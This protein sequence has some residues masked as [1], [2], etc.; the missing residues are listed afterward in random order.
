MSFGVSGAGGAVSSAAAGGGFGGI[1]GTSG[2]GSMYSRDAQSAQWPHTAPDPSAW[3]NSRSQEG[4]LVATPGASNQSSRERLHQTSEAA[5]RAGSPGNQAAPVQMLAVLL[6]TLDHH[7]SSRLD[8][9]EKHITSLSS[10]IQ[11]PTEGQARIEALLR[12]QLEKLGQMEAQQNLKDRQL[13]SKLADPTTGYDSYEPLTYSAAPTARSR[14]SNISAISSVPAERGYGGQEVISIDFVTPVFPEPEKV[15]QLQDTTPAYGQP[16]MASDPMATMDKLVRNMDQMQGKLDMI[17]HHNKSALSR[18]HDIHSKI[19]LPTRHKQAN[20]EPESKL[21]APGSPTTDSHKHKDLVEALHNAMGYA[22]KHAHVEYHLPNRFHD[23]TKS[24]IFHTLTVFS[25]LIHALLTGVETDYVLHYLLEHTKFLEGAV[26]HD[27]TEADFTLFRIADW[28]VLAWWIFELAVYVLAQG[29]SF[30]YPDN[31]MFPWNVFDTICVIFTIIELV[32]DMIGSAIPGIFTQGYLRLIRVARVIRVLR[33]V[34]VVRWFQSVRK[35]LIAV[36]GAL[37]TLGWALFL[38]ALLIYLFAIM[39]STAIVHYYTEEHNPVFVNSTS[40]QPLIPTLTHTEQVEDYYGGVIVIMQT[41]FMA[42]TGGDWTVMSVP[43]TDVSWI[44]KVLWFSYVSF[45]I[46]GLLNVFTGIFVESATHAANS[47]REI[48]MQAEREDEESTLNSIRALF[49][50]SGYGKDGHVTEDA[51]QELM[52]QND[53]KGQLSALGLH[54]SEAH[55]LFKLLDGDNS[56]FV[57][58]DEFLSG[59]LRLKGT[60][61]AVDMVTLLFETSK[62]NRKMSRMERLL[63]GEAAVREDEAGGFDADAP[64]L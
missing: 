45:V 2:N 46:F 33:L 29:K 10:R 56:G 15:P 37:W 62:M 21:G 27:A 19:H 6:E 58:I 14:D 3:P 12:V 18:I 39:M 50:S 48:V 16:V 53:F 24:P 38:L 31:P 9:I 60:A 5:A 1:L 28:I 64:L 47:D 35:L 57:S 13:E 17:H 34:K 43:L 4:A 54:T 49:S 44:C 26:A 40:S 55:G 51:L 36:Q 42:I 22:A 23:I 63:V 30:V 52:N 20:P 32:A 61:R 11:G 59:C 7:L 25:I 41:L 8:T